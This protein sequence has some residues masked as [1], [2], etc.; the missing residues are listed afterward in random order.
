[1]EALAD[2]PGQFRQAGVDSGDVD[3]NGPTPDLTP[4][5]SPGKGGERGEGSG[6]EERRHKRQ[7]VVFAA[8]IQFRALLPAIPEGTDGG[9][10]LAQFA[11][12]GCGPGHPKAALDVRLDLG[13]QAKD[14]ASAGL[15][16]QVPGSVG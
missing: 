5:P 4:G 7:L 11:G 12:H 8:E 14:E 9:D 16:R 6:I 1:M 10:L 3:G 13:A 2:L 15:R